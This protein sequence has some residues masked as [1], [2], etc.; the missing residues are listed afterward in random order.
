MCSVVADPQRCASHAVDAG[1][2]ADVLWCVAARHEGRWLLAGVSE[3]YE[4][5][6]AR[7]RLARRRFGDEIEIFMVR[8]AEA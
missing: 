2:Q 7:A 5:A 4:R 6:L 1:P 3:E 8:P